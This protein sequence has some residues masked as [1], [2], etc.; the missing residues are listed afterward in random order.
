[1]SPIV[2]APTSPRASMISTSPGETV[3]TASF[4]GVLGALARFADVL[5]QSRRSAACARSPPSAGPGAVGRRPVRNVL[6]TPRFA[7]WTVSVAV[8]T[9]RNAASAS[10]DS[11][12]GR[13]ALTPVAN[14][15]ASAVARGM[16]PYGASGSRRPPR[17]C[18]ARRP[19][20]S[21][22]TSTTS[23]GSTTPAPAGVPVRITS[24]ALERHEARQVGDQLPE[25]EDQ[26]VGRGLLD[27]LA[28]DARA[29]AAAT[30]GRRRRRPRPGRSACSRPV[31]S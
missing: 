16:A 20:P 17:S 21:S 22:S 14:A 27:D 3:S 18:C 28:V 19:T 6:A 29:S 7:S 26:V 30:R 13:G 11:V 10:A 8:E 15:R 9:R 12:T 2:P 31:P 1:M 24:P 25:G 4:C 23:P 5:A